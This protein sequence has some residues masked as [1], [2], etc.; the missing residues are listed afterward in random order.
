ML[1][2]IKSNL[3]IRWE[4]IN[5]KRLSWVKI[6][7]KST[8]GRYVAIEVENGVNE[9]STPNFSELNVLVFSQLKMRKG[10]AF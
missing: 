3:V 9:R 4:Y 8:R 7:K 1:I 6:S 2:V 10:K 5:W